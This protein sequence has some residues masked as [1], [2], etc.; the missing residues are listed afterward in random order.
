MNDAMQE[1]QEIKK[2]IIGD[3]V[4]VND[5]DDEHVKKLRQMTEKLN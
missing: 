5:D 2:I 4:H 3:D 1:V